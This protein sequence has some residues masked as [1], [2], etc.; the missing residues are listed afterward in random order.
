MAKGKRRRA[1]GIKKRAIKEG[2]SANGKGR[3]EIKEGYRVQSVVE[4]TV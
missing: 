1:E 4:E 3:K 2:Q